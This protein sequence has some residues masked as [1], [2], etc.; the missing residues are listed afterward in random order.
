MTLR[1]VRQYYEAKKQFENELEAAKHARELEKETS[2]KAT[3]QLPEEENYRGVKDSPQWDIDYHHLIIPLLHVLIGLLNNV[4][5]HLKKFLDDEVEL[6]PEEERVARDQYKSELPYGENLQKEVEK[7]KDKIAVKDD[8][9]TCLT[10]ERL[11]ISEAIQENLDMRKELKKSLTSLKTTS[12]THN[13]KQDISSLRQKLKDLETKA[14]E[15]RSRK[16]SY[17]ETITRTKEQKEVLVARKAQYERSLKDQ[18]KVILTKR[19]IWTEQAKKRVGKLENGLDAKFEKIL[20][21][22]NIKP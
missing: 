7:Y 21:T 10:A 1:S 5:G 9:L 19:S 14:K 17:G 18:R 2:G 8:E 12:S 22:Y 11:A 13:N 15:F 20:Y 3:T 4:L 6:L 16:K